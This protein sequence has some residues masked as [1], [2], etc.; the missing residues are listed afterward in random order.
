M[1]FYKWMADDEEI[2]GTPTVEFD[3]EDG[4]TVDDISIADGGKTVEFFLSE[5][6][7]APTTRLRLNVTV[8]TDGGQT[9]VG[10]GIVIV[11]ST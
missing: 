8:T 11:S 6:E 3:D 10:D 2:T 7:H 5:G 9:L 1:P 4:P